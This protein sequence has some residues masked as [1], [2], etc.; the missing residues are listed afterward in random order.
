M[1]RLPDVIGPPDVIP[2]AMR[3]I[4][5]IANLDRDGAWG[6]DIARGTGITGPVSPVTRVTRAV[7]RRTS[8]IFISASAYAHYDWKEK[9]Q[10]SQSFRFG[11]RFHIALSFV[12]YPKL[13]TP[14]NETRVPYTVFAGP[15]YDARFF[16]ISVPTQPD[17]SGGGKRIRSEPSALNQLNN[18]HND[19]NHEQKMDQAASNVT[20]KAKKPEHH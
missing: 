19:S 16:Q 2:G 20:N 14:A 3:V 4:R 18:E 9:E 7:S 6:G 11:F 5:P 17:N 1:S 10:E 12:S 13:A 15:E 8:I